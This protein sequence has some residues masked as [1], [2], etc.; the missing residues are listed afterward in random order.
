MKKIYFLAV[1]LLLGA[2]A[3]AQTNLSFETW[4]AGAPDSWDYFG[5]GFTSN[6]FSGVGDLTDENGDPVT[7]VLQM[8]DTPSDGVSYIRSTSF[9]LSNST[10][11]T[12]V[13]D[14]PY[15]SVSYQLFASTDKY[16]D[17]SFDVKYDVLGQDE[18]IVYVQANDA[19]GD[20][21]G[22]GFTEFTG[23]QPL[24]LT[25]TVAIT[26]FTSEPIVEYELIIASSAQALFGTQAPVA[27]P[28]S[29]LDVDNIELGNIIVDAPNVSN[30]VASD[31]SDNCDGSDL[32]VTF[33]V[34]ADEANIANYYLL[35]TTPD[36]S[37]GQLQDPLTTFQTVGVQITPDGTDQTHVFAAGDLYYYIDNG[38]L[39]A[40]PIEDGIDLVVH[41][42]VE[43]AN[44]SSDVFNVSNTINLDCPT[45]SLFENEIESANVY[46]NPASDKVNFDFGNNTIES[47]TITDMN[48][49][50]VESVHGANTFVT[51]DLNGLENGVYFYNAVDNAG[52]VISTNK[53]VVNK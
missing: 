47:L 51:V 22:Q 52:N 32:E 18:A 33:E 21:V 41:V 40:A 27:E 24:F 37:P 3:I 23:N 7:P 4:A 49:R 48:G 31:I 42:Y 19:N 1:S 11:P 6:A 45:N 2:G 17:V 29:V 13:P 35:V 16:E 43:G 12:N 25:E 36:I 5:Q 10:Q 14:G 50:V 28:G 15:G 9:L 38:Q 46:P 34:P 26:Y 30:V 20:V 8:T 53:F 44:G 39:A